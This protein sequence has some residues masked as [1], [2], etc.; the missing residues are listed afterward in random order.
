MELRHKEW[1]L[2]ILWSM[3]LVYYSFVPS[4][5]G[6]KLF[7][8]KALHMAS[9]FVLSLFYFNALKQKGE[10]AVYYSIFFATMYGLLLEL[11][12]LF[13]PYRSFSMLD[14][15]VNSVGALAAPIVALKIA[16]KNGFEKLADW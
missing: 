6:A 14:L 4:V 1:V 10:N 11:M 9:Y 16:E 3:V 2:V 13:I 5:P 12:Q 7:G 8:D 15:A